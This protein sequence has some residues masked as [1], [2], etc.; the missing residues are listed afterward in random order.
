MSDG[1]STKAESAEYL[2][3]LY[4]GNARRL[5]EAEP[6]QR[7][8]SVSS[9][10]WDSLRRHVFGRDNYI[11]TYC[12]REGQRLECDHITS[13]ADGG[14]DDTDNLTTACRPCNRSKGRRSG[15]DWNAS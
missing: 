2:S 11:C 15:R 3:H 12:A 7:K 1:W 5:D 13:V 8:L 4:D 6:I 10:E 9:H 14:S